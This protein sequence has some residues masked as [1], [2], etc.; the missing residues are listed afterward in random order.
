VGGDQS[1][2]LPNPLVISP[3]THQDAPTSRSH[4]LHLAP[5]SSS[6]HT[7]PD[8]RQTYPERKDADGGHA[9]LSQGPGGVGAA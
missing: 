5:S 7:H 2:Y 1:H 9:L 4:K 3:F 6:L 8:E